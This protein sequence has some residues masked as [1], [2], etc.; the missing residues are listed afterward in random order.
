MSDLAETAV[1]PQPTPS[2]QP[3][4][5]VHE[6]GIPS[7]ASKARNQPTHPRNAVTS[8]SLS[9][10]FP[11]SLA[12]FKRFL[13]ELTPLTRPDIDPTTATAIAAHVPTLTA[14]AIQ[15]ALCLG[16]GH[17]GF[18]RTDATKDQYPHLYVVFPHLQRPIDERF[19]RL[20]HTEIVKP[21]F[22]EAWVASRLADVYEDAELQW[23]TEK[24]APTAEQVLDRFYNVPGYRRHRP[25]NIGWPGWVDEWEYVEHVPDRY[26]LA[27]GAEGGFSDTRAW[28]FDEA[29]TAM[30]DMLKGGDEPEEM[31]DPILLAVWKKTL[32]VQEPGFEDSLVKSV[33]KEWDV[34]VDSR[35]VEPGMFFVHVEG[36]DD[37]AVEP[38]LE[39]EGSGGDTWNGWLQSLRG[40]WQWVWPTV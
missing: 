40:V 17:T 35:F 19:W 28:V 13:W 4:N 10:A 24:A 8:I 9:F 5:L 27:K 36:T 14:D 26:A 39:P 38:H 25:Q 2:T 22:D 7:I 1:T 37:H 11:T 32:E 23:I 29:W 6:S 15:S 20:W 18:K 33:G 34:Y 31:S 16:V 3:E 21:A 30:R 12:F